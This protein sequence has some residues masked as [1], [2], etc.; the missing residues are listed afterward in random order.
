[1]TETTD[2]GQRR[3]TTFLRPRS[4]RARSQVAAVLVGVSLLSILAVGAFNFVQARQVLN[5]AARARLIDISASRAHRIED[6]M[7]QRQDLVTTMANDPAVVEALTELAEGYDQLDPSLSAAEEQELVAF[8]EGRSPPTPPGAEP[9]SAESL[10][11]TTVDARYLQYHYI[12][13]NPF[14]LRRRS[15]L[16]RA[17]DDSA[18]TRAHAKHHPMLRAF[19]EA[20]DLGDVLLID[21]ATGNVVYT[22]EKRID[23]ATDIEA[24]PHRA[25]GL[26]R[27][28]RE[29]LATAGEDEAV[30]IDFGPYQAN[31]NYPTS[32]VAATIRDGAEILGAVVVRVGGQE[33]NQIATAG[34]DW[35]DTGLGETGEVYVVGPDLVM[36]TNSRLMAEDP[37][38]YLGAVEA[39]G[40]DSEISD[41]AEAFGTSALI[42]PVETEAAETA[43][44]GETFSAEVTSNYL[45]D[46]TLTVA[47]P[48]DVD[49]VQ[50]AMVAD[51]AT[52][53]AF[54]PINRAM[55]SVLLVAAILVPLVALV[56]VY[57]ANRLLR[58]LNP[59]VT[60][61]RRVGEGDLDA[62][63][64]DEDR[65]EFGELGRNFNGLV[66]AMRDQRAEL[67][68]TDAETTELLAA[69]VPSRFVDQVKRGDREL[70]E[71]VRNA[72]VIA[73]SI[74]PL[75]G[76]A[77]MESVET[78]D[79]FVDLLAEM[80]DL[81]ELSDV[82]QIRASA[83][84][85]L[86]AAGLS[87]PDRDAERAV[88][89]VVAARDLTYEFGSARGI[90]FVF[91]AGLAAGDVI[92][93]VVGTERLAFDMWGEPR[94]VALALASVA[95]AG[96]I[97]VD[98]SVASEAEDGWTLARAHDLTGLGGDALPAWTVEG[99]NV[100]AGAEE[101]ESVP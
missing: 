60:A 43:L 25:T 16:L 56:G 7:Q 87:T 34:E 27:V 18:Y 91:K 15:E 29:R 38:A 70:A 20:S 94:R 1:M 40:Y 75:A 30:V 5:E 32:F 100:E 37:A 28:V 95:E 10:L 96:E 67:A 2:S 50:W 14:G 81:A 36:R 68:R 45:G 24:G 98:A 9:A 11:P 53:E 84:E 93:A 23:F 58:P 21:A 71:S 6:A 31:G 65:T 89:F 8:Y 74:E 51:M 92:G 52:G 79:A 82:E 73:T 48:L 39:A 26:A 78:A 41:A 44:G 62:H 99:R 66:A 59:I 64:P 47:H 101:S 83:S 12:V 57:L 17:T 61:V 19:S 49:G 22:V 33:L 88:D 42:Q 35:R 69:V 97:L 86:F 13:E 3:R 54:A 46:D 80:A 63:L 4:W 55:R 76:I 72:T 90:D 85:Q 77:A